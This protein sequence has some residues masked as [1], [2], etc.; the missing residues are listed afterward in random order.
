MAEE[1]EKQASPTKRQAVDALESVLILIKSTLQ[2][3]EDVAIMGFGDA[4][5]GSGLAITHCTA[6]SGEAVV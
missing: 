4:A 6:T 2:R 5:R 3:G 1:I